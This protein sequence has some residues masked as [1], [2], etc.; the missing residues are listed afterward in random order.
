[1]VYAPVY[2]LKEEARLGAS[3]GCR[4][5]VDES[6]QVTAYISRQGPGRKNS[7]IAGAQRPGEGPAYKIIRQFAGYAASKT[8]QA[9]SRYG[10]KKEKG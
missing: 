8:R 3:E 5:E 10:A 9:R 2:T 6:G 1:M 4:S 7:V